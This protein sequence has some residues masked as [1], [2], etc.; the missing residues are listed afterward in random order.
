L[1]AARQSRPP[2]HLARSFIV[3]QGLLMSIDDLSVMVAGRNAREHEREQRAQAR[4]TS[5]H[6]LT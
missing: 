6:F 2:P 4:Q 3:L 5:S 1:W